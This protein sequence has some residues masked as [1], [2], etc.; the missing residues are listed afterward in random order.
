MQLV[1]L[2]DIEL[3]ALQHLDLMDEHILKRVNTLRAL[4]DLTAH[5]LRDQLGDEFPQVAR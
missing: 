1:K 3:G 5:D 2:V 4:F